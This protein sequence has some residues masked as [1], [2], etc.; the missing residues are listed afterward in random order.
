MARFDAERGRPKDR[1]EPRRR[2]SWYRDRTGRPFSWDRLCDEM[3][4][5]RL[6]D[7]DLRRGTNETE[8]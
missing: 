7:F 2:E 8:P 4:R 1:L 3:R 5:P 6:D